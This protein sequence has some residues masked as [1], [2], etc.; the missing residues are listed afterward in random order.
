MLTNNDLANIVNKGFIS[1]RH[2]GYVIFQRV[3]TFAFHKVG[4]ESNYTSPEIISDE[5]YSFYS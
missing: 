4:Q 3:Q 5:N 1:T 2:R